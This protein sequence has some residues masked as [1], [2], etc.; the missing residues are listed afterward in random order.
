MKTEQFEG[1]KME[2][3]KAAEAESAARTL[4]GKTV[5]KKKALSE[6]LNALQVELREAKANSALA[7]EKFLADAMEKEKLAKI[8]RAEAAAAECLDDAESLFSSLAEQI[9]KQERSA[10]EAAKE[11]ARAANMYW[12]AVQAELEAEFRQ[13]TTPILKRLA[14]LLVVGGYHKS[15]KEIGSKVLGNDRM[16][17]DRALFE[18]MKDEL[19]AEHGVPLR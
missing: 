18:S 11:A 5:E 19:A 15:F 14:T 16:D 9:E 13:M 6:G 7:M 10:G 17:L 1:L 8:R 2:Y 4:L 3:Q 12:Q